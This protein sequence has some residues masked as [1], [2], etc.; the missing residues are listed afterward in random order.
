MEK[1]STGDQVTLGLTAVCSFPVLT[2]TRFPPEFAPSLLSSS[3]NQLRQEVNDQKS[4]GDLVGRKTKGRMCGWR[5]DTAKGERDRLKVERAWW[6]PTGIPLP[7]PHTTKI[8][9]SS[10]CLSTPHSRS[11]CDSRPPPRQKRAHVSLALGG[12]GVCE[13]L[14]CTHRNRRV[15]S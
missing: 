6:H 7:N 9:R 15:P 8:Y 3:L 12:Q 2:E 4:L 13:G 1:V 14:R 11:H 10:G 5:E